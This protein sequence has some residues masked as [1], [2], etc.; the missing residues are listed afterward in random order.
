MKSKLL[1]PLALVALAALAAGVWTV[2][3]GGPPAELQALGGGGRA[4]AGPEEPALPEVAREP[5]AAPPR[6]DRSLETTVVLP[7]EL[8]LELVEAR[9]RLQADGEPPLGHSR[10]ARLRGSIHGADGRAARGA[11]AEILA[12]PNAGRVLETDADGRFGASDLYAGLAL[13]ALRAPGTPGAEREVLLREGSEAQLNVGFGRPSTLRGRVTDEANQPLPLARVVVD[14]QEVAT[15]ENGVFEVRGVA[16]GKVPVYVLKAGYAAHREMLFVTAGTHQR[17]D[18]LRYVLRRGCGAKVVVPERLGLGRPG[19]LL[20]SG[21]V[22]GTAARDFPWHLV[23]TREV[24]AGETVEFEDLPRGMARFQLFVPGARAL[25]ASQ[26]VA[27]FP[28]Q[29]KSVTFH[30]EAAPVLVGRVL[31]EGAPVA[32]ARVQLEAPDVTGAASRLLG[33]RL[34]RAQYE[35]EL[36]AQAPPAVQVVRTRGDGGF[37]FSAAEDVAAKRYLTAV[38]PD[39]RGW[40]GRIVG[41]GETEVTLDLV[42]RAG[43]EARLVIETSERFQALPVSYVV[44]GVPHKAV[45]AAGER[46]ELEGL[47]EGRWRVRARWENEKML[48]GL[49]LELEGSR[50]LFVPLPQGAIDGQ[51]RSFRDAMR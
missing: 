7:L 32:N 30:L 5:L 9:G 27:L 39:G 41:P 45:L 47:A 23:G 36:L 3:S 29:V 12:G 1:L 37:E 49:E 51:S 46:L 43:G 11:F 34:G 10:S 17:D 31:R 8:E 20:V 22:D 18:T 40:A 2:L 13:V 44:D 33:E 6:Q 14:G 28:D 25:P 35:V 4:A 24:F 26:Q 48:D 38:G 19:T 42:E 50:D 15:D 16:S 21:P